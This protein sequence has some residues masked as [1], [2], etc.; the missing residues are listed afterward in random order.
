VSLSVLKMW[1]SFFP[2]FR[3]YRVLSTIVR[4]EGYL[5]NTFF[6]FNFF[7]LFRKLQFHIGILNEATSSTLFIFTACQSPVGQGLLTVE[8]SSSHSGSSH[9]VGLLWTSDRPFSETSTSQHTTVRRDRHTF[10]GG[11]RI[12][13]P[14]KQAAADPHLRPRD[15]YG[16]HIQ[17]ACI[18]T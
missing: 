2:Y 10:P 9:S 15:H 1:R 11:I 12:R 4:E 17:I 8:V 5:A 6:I 16:R 3:T 14:N 13:N 7:K 18:W